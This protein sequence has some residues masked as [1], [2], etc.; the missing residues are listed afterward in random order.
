MK[1]IVQT[2]GVTFFPRHFLFSLV[3]GKN[4]SILLFHAS[5]QCLLVF[6]KLVELVIL[7]VKFKEYICQ[8]RVY[9]GKPGIFKCLQTSA[10]FADSEV[11][12][13]DYMGVIP[14]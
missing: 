2:K 12:V 3:S 13:L 9:K 7:G 14:K 5:R 4:F 8:V 6:N 10:P 11:D 1:G